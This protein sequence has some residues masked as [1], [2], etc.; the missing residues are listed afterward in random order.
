MDKKIRDFFE[1]ILNDGVSPVYS[2][3]AEKS[4]RQ[5]LTLSGLLDKLRAKSKKAPASEAQK[6]DESKAS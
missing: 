4:T 6:P 1:S 2:G 3:P 5:G